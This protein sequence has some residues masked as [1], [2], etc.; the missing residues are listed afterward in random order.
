MVIAELVYYI[1]LLLIV[2]INMKKID[3]VISQKEN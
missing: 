2:I 1:C 3:C